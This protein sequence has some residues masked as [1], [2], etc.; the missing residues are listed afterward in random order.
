M[1]DIVIDNTLLQDALGQSLILGI[2][3]GAYSQPAL[4]QS[5]AAI[6]LG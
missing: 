5:V 1:T 6:T 3:R 2:Q 4:V